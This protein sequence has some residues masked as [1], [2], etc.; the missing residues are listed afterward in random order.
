MMTGPAQPSLNGPQ[1]IGVGCDVDK[2][3]QH[4]NRIGKKYDMYR[5]RATSE[6]IALK[7]VLLPIL[8]SER[9]Q[10]HTAT[11]MRALIGNLNLGCT[12][13][14]VGEKGNPLSREKA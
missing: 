12:F 6:M 5:A 11:R 7:A 3:L 14:K 4:R 10:I 1:G 8:S 13:A 9:R 2:R